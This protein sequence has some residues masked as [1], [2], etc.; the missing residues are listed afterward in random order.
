MKNQVLNIPEK[1]NYVRPK[2]PNI[3]FSKAERFKKNK[4]YEGSIYLFK[5]GIFAPKTQEDFFLKEPFSGKA[6]RTFFGGK[7][8]ITPSPAEYKIKSSFELIA[9]QGKKI[10]ENRKRIKMREMK[11][12]QDKSSFKKSNELNKK[13]NNENNNSE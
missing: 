4:E 5:D 11:E 10:S 1:E 8:D 6:Q 3:S 12:V 2:L 7:K 9:D 13:L